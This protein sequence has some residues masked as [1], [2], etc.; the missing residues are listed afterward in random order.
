MVRR[1]HPSGAKAHVVWSSGV[2]D[3]S[4]AGVPV[5]VAG[6]S[7]A[8]AIYGTT[9]V[10]L[11]APSG[12]RRWQASLSNRLATPCASHC[13]VVAAGRLVTLAEDGTVQAFDATSGAQ[14]WSMRL[15][16]TPRWLE[17]AGEDVLV[18]QTAATGGPDLSILVISAATGTART[19]TPSCPAGPDIPI[20]AGATDEDGLFVS[21]DGTALTVLVTTSGGCALRY[22]LADGA[23]LWRTATDEENAQIPF[24][25]TGESAA[26]SATTLAWTNDQGLFALDV[27]TGAIRQLLTIPRSMSFS[28]RGI[29]G[30]TLF[31]ES[32]LESD[33]DRPATSAYDLASGK[34][35]WQVA[36]R[37]SRSG[38]TQALDLSATGPVIVSCSSDADTCVFEAIDT[39]TGTIKGSFRLPAE[40]GQVDEVHAT[41]T[42]TSLEVVVGWNHIVGLD[43]TTAAVQ[44]RWPS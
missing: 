14:S 39:A 1:V 35:L 3:R 25:L 13:A 5:V 20:N 30:S 29:V 2:L 22:R 16:S 43:P 42:T 26:Q 34:Q 17:V 11:D 28:L 6:P 4:D 24:T 36:T 8:I 12:Q 21:P 40:P 23:M 19:L 27:A 9:V 38:D 44:W 10:A 37:V 41:A 7:Q 32:A 15:T 31:V 18:D 33:S